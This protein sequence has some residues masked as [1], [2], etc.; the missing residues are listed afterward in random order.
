VLFE[1]LALAQA[2]GSRGWLAL[3]TEF[4]LLGLGEGLAEHCI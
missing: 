1:A 2:L 3:F 4:A